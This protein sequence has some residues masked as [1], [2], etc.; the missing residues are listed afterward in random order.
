[1][2]TVRF[3]GGETWSSVASPG[4]G[5]SGNVGDFG[6]EVF[7]TRARSPSA[8]SASGSSASSSSMYMFW[9]SLQTFWT[10]RFAGASGNGGYFGAEVFRTPWSAPG[11]SHPAGRPAR[12]PSRRPTRRR[13]PAVSTSAPPV[14]PRRAASQLSFRRVKR[15]RLQVRTSSRERGPS[16]STLRVVYPERSR[17]TLADLQRCRVL[18]SPLPPSPGK[19]PSYSGRLPL[20]LQ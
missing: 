9:T 8:A 11:P 14:A 13:R 4:S 17:G 16:P 1:M 2:R 10:R 5:T 12:T 18:P 7:K 6:A 19:P 20:P 3:A 15:R